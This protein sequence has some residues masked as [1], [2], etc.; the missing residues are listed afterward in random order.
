MYERLLSETIADWTATGILS[1]VVAVVIE[2]WAVNTDRHDT[3]AGDDALTLGL[4]SSRNIANRIEAEFLP[5]RGVIADQHKNSLRVIHHG[6]TLRIYK[7]GGTTIDV[8]PESVD[9]NTSATKLSGPMDNTLMQQLSLTDVPEGKAAF[10]GSIPEGPEHLH[11]AWAGDPS[12]S[13]VAVYVG[14]PRDNRAGGSPWYAVE[15]VHRDD[16]QTPLP[17]VSTSTNGTPR[18]D[19]LSVPALDVRAR[20]EQTAE[21]SE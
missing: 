8:D 12:D 17:V 9:W 7:L 19:E 14:F 3:G 21:E 1:E 11:L 5:R 13:K 10:A 20:R 15:C 16:L 18:Y 2:V 4:V 6:R